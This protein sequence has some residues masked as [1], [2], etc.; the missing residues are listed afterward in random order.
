MPG[1]GQPEGAT[2]G[3]EDVIVFAAGGQL[4]RVSARGGEPE[5]LGKLAEGES[6]RFWPQFLPDGRHYLYLSLAPRPEDQGIYVG[7]LDSDLRKRIVATEYNAAYSP[8]GHLL[9]VKDEALM[10]QPFDA[11]SLELSGEP[12]PVIE[13]LALF[14]GAQL[15]P[16]RALFRSPRTACS[17]GARP[18]G[19]P[20]S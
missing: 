3:R 15:A 9:F 8:S 16:W 14:K 13:Q 6:A 20:S 1:I 10:A 18:P 5:P 2:W 4:F 12:F 11:T 7:S 17:P 19:S